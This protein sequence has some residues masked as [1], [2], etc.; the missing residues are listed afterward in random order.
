MITP[1]RLP[2]LDDRCACYGQWLDEDMWVTGTIVAISGSGA[3]VKTDQGKELKVPHRRL[4]WKKARS[5]W[6][7][8][9]PQVD[10]EVEKIRTQRGG[11][12]RS[13]YNRKL[14]P[15]EYVRCQMGTKFVGGFVCRVLLEGYMITIPKEKSLVPDAGVGNFVISADMLSYD[16]DR[17]CWQA[18]YT[19]VKP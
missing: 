16:P 7:V 14:V 8:W 18:R 5:E 17:L 15:G 9:S 6:A 12:G 2:E 13:K 11:D 4:T 3:T 1:A 19:R 10:Q